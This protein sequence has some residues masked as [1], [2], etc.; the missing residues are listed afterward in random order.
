MR[1]R[2]PL[3]ALLF[4]VGFF[5]LPHIAHAGIPFFGPIIPDS[6]IPGN[7][8]AVCPASWGMMMTV[9][10]NIISLL[11]T[12]FIVFLTP[13]VLA[14]AGFLLVFNQGDPGKISEAKKVVTNTI[15]GIVVALASWMIVDAVMAVLYSPGNAGGT[16]STMIFSSGDFCLPQKGALSS[17]VLDPTK[18]APSVTPGAGT[19]LATDLSNVPG[20]PC[21]PATIMAAAPATA[22]QANQLACVAKGE[23][24]CGT[25]NPP[26]NLNYS[27]GI[28][29]GSS[30]KASTAAGAYQVLLSSNHDCYEKKP[31]YAAVGLPMDGG[32][33]LNC[34]TGF[35]SK[36][37]P[38]AG[39]AVVETCKKAA[40]NVA[41]SAAAA[42]CLLGKQS[43]ASAYA[44][45]PYT[46]SCLSAYPG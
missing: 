11:L 30:G 1:S 3:F 13:L 35:D 27:W 31:C 12:V 15:V 4:T 10:N 16:W 45:D 28:A 32:T 2:T 43:F 44:T 14:Y 38:I 20:N 17:D 34:Q 29:S 5:A 23:S 40:G 7:I 24:T 26:Y 39:S 21:N 36:G 42:V 37:F 18:T 41:C 9:I 25:K 6:N 8:N 22:A 33:K 19:T 46:A